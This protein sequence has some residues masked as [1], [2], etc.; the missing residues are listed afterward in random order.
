MEK[1]YCSLTGVNEVLMVDNDENI[2]EKYAQ[3]VIGRQYSTQ[4]IMQW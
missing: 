1:R 3:N 4:I 2:F